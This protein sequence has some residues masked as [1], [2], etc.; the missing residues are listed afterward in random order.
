M[1]SLLR[2]LLL[3]TRERCDHLLRELGR[4]GKRLP[5]DVVPFCDRWLRLVQSYRDEIETL[6]NDP[7]LDHPQLASNL[8]IDYKIVTQFL[9]EVEAG[10]LVRSSYHAH[11][12]EAAAHR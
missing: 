12:Q 2:D 1:A 3:D 6:I 7:D 11:A 8:Y 4:L 5:A 9:F 10:P